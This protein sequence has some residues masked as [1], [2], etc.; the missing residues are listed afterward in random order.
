MKCSLGISNFLEEISSLSHFFFFFF[1]SIS[2]HWSLRKAFLSLLAIL[3]NSAFR[4]L[5]LSFSPL[6]FTA[7]CKASPDSHFA[8]L[9]F[10]SMRMVL[11]PVSCTMSRTSFHSSSG[12]LFI[13]SRPLNLF[14]TYQVPIICWALSQEQGYSGSHSGIIP[15]HR[16]MHWRMTLQ[17]RDKVVAKTSANFS[18]P[19]FSQELFFVLFC[20]LTTSN[21]GGG[22]NKGQKWYGPNRSR[23]Y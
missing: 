4:C 13:R 16:K 5:Y 9:H 21:S 11:I 7:I 20:F 12:T 6:L 18:I 15:T 23:R 22:L 1:P 10:F 19:V 8:F 2:L 17:R 14:L 3:W